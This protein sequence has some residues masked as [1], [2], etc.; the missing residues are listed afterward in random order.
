[1]GYDNSGSF[2]T[3]YNGTG[4]KR[5]RAIIGDS[6]GG[7]TVMPTIKPGGGYTPCQLLYRLSSPITQFVQ[8]DGS[9]SLLEGDNFI[10]A[11]CGCV[12][13]ERITPA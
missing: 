10:E 1:M 6:S 13:R 4:A 3:P 8:E 12:S 2:A 7:V 11:G 5:W 9:L